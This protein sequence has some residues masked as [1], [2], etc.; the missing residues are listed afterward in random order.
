MINR[1]HI[2]CHPDSGQGQ[3][4]EILGKVLAFLDHYQVYY[5]VHQTTTINQ[6]GLMAKQI[7]S[8]IMQSDNNQ[9]LIIGGD[10]TLHD[11]V[12]ALWEMNQRIP[13]NYIPTGTGNDFARA[14]L[15]GQSYQDILETMLFHPQQ[16]EVPI[17][18]YLNQLDNHAGIILN[19]MGFGFDALTN[20]KTGEF[21]AQLNP[22]LKRLIHKLKLAYLCGL[23]LSLSSVPKFSLRLI[24]DGQPIDWQDVSILTIVNNPT[25][26][27]GIQID[28]LARAEAEELVAILYHHID[29]AAIKELL[30]KVLIHK[31]Q[32]T[33]THVQR[34]VADSLKLILDQPVQGQVDGESFIFPKMEISFEKSSYP[35]ILKGSTV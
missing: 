13:L 25:L 27:G 21:M 12:Q 3:G 8:Q 6:A 23:V 26:G 17:F 14:W 29:F 35:F 2:I 22:F 24:V 33:S 4:K 1:V 32:H 20:R 9:L 30:A 18:T 15:K 11:V 7:A 5:Q 10:G 16:V 19:S 28:N 31:N 34:Y